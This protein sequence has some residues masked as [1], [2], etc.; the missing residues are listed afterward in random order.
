MQQSDNNISAFHV[1]A[2]PAGAICNLDCCYCFYL[3]K[4]YLYPEKTIYKMSDKVLESF[5]RQKIEAHTNQQVTFT[6]QGGEPTLLG[7]EFFE[8][9]VILQQKYACG[10]KINN[11]LRR[12]L[13]WF[14]SKIH[15]AMTF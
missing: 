2:K 9:V 3:K 11:T 5:I 7:I 6:W 14:N 8:K 13:S 1:M 15:Q 4:E 10:K 12:D